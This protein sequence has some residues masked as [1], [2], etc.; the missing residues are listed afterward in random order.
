MNVCNRETTNVFNFS[1]EIPMRPIFVV[2]IERELLAY[3]PI[4]GVYAVREVAR[5]WTMGTT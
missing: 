3:I 4:V 5:Q 1:N 2:V